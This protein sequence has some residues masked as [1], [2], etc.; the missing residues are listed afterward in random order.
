MVAVS[1]VAQLPVVRS[2]ADGSTV[3]VMR[4]GVAAQAGDLVLAVVSARVPWDEAGI[5]AG[6]GVVGRWQSWGRMDSP[7]ATPQGV[8]QHGGW[9]PTTYRDSALDQDLVVGRLLTAAD[10]AAMNAAWTVST[11]MPRPAIEDD[12]RAVPVEVAWLFRGERSAPDVAES[13]ALSR[14]PVDATEVR[15]GLAA[16][17]VRTAFPAPYEVMPAGGMR[18]LAVE[19]QPPPDVVLV[20]VAS[21]VVAGSA[22]A[23]T[24][25]VWIQDF[26]GSTWP[27]SGLYYMVARRVTTSTLDPTPL[28]PRITDPG[29]PAFI[30]VEAA[31]WPVTWAHDPGMAGAQAKYR[32]RRTTGSTV[33]YW[34]HAS[35][36]WVPGVTDN[37]S[38]VNSASIQ[39][40]SILNGETF[41]LEVATQGAAYATWSPWSAAVTVTGA[42]R[43]T[44]V[45]TIIERDAVSGLVR[46]ATPTVVV[47]GSPAAGLAIT[48]WEVRLWRDA[49]GTGV[50][51]QQSSGVVTAP[52]TPRAL[53]D[54]QAYTLQARAQQT[55]GAWSTWVDLALTVDVPTPAAPTVTADPGWAHETSGAP[56]VLVASDFPWAGLDFTFDAPA[57]VRVHR[58]VD[59]GPWVGIG[60]TGYE[61]GTSVWELVDY[62]AP[63]GGQVEYRSRAEV[64]FDD[65]G[66][67]IGPW[68]YSAPVAAPALVGGWVIDVE[69][70]E[71]AMRLS[72]AEDE[73]REWDLRS[74][75]IAAIGRP[76]WTVALGVPMDQTGKMTAATD[77]ATELQRLVDLLLSGGLLVL[78][79]CHERSGSDGSRSR[80][81]VIWMRV[82]GGSVSASRVSSGPF[83]RRLVSWSWVSQPAPEVD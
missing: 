3:Q 41:T 69:R 35:Q 40:G 22:A 30:D 75:P 63:A 29:S 7:Y 56:G 49:A 12:S 72:L 15:S 76:D 50:L 24:Y 58:R 32:L 70:P 11:L 33:T 13:A 47:T 52:W 46:D 19:L 9:M 25:P 81:E 27:L 71:T 77:D 68:G 83:Q 36:T 66:E 57:R 38:T 45:A 80:G 82:A 21:R 61:L 39:A 18:E 65:G 5:A 26:Y 67:S 20:R 10:V 59:G 34:D 28:R 44:A 64:L 55:G 53:T 73:A 4:A 43:P 60:L 14:D 51:E 74:T 31:D 16:L 79:M 2:G 48:R 37:T 6:W 42:P 62:T 17:E 1:L 54:G 78:R 23:A 8:Q